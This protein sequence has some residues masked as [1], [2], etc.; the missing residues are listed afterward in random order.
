MRE[1]ILAA[2]VAVL[3]CIALV[4]PTLGI[5]A[6]VWF[7]LMRPD[8]LA[9]SSGALP[10]SP[11]LAVAT[12]AGSLRYLPRYPLLFTNPITRSMM[13]LQVIYLASVIFALEQPESLD[14][15]Y[16]FLRMFVVVLAILPCIVTLEDLRRLLL[17]MA[18]SLGVV[19]LKFG[20][21]GLLHGGAR[22]N[23]GYGGLMSDNNDLALGMAM[24]FPL[25]WYGRSLA[26]GRWA[27]LLLLGLMLGCA[28]TVIVT[29]SRGGALSLGVVLLMLAWRSGKRLASIVL[30]ALCIAPALYLVRNSYMDRM[31]TLA[32]PVKE[33]SALSRLMYA[34]AALKIG[35][36]YPI[37]G[38][39]FGGQG[40]ISIQGRYLQ[41]WARQQVVHNTYLQI[42]VDSGAFALALYLA[43]LFG[44]IMWLGR[45]AREARRLSPGTELYPY[46]IQ[47]A[48]IAFAIGSTF[49][50]KITFDLSYMLFAAAACWYALRP[51]QPEA[52]ANAVPLDTG[53]EVCLV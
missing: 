29:H 37:A 17:V 6:Y 38:L 36:D 30:V 27:R 24:A 7:S 9:W 46:A 3:A 51:E 11:M 19:G 28:T 16:K 2:V 33:D 13:A 53:V 44:T 15:Y 14:S 43:T 26:N 49:L 25:C 50:S 39:G 40:Y 1:L 52:V 42:L 47:S 4:R 22:F 41:D 8:L 20:A 34:R 31:A 48:L 32:A 21:Y 12:L 35:M 45:S 23:M 10:Y 18:V 5:L